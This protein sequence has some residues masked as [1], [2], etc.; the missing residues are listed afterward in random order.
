MARTV[1]L[2]NLLAQ[3]RYLGNIQGMTAR[4][5]DS[6]LTRAINQS[7]QHF[8]E[9]VSAH[10]VRNYLTHATGTLSVG[11]TSPFAFTVLD[12]SAVSPAIVRVFGLDITV[13]GRV[14]PLEQIDFDSRNDFQD[15]TAT[16]L[17]QEPVAYANYQQARLAIFPASSGAYPYTVHYLPVLADLTSGFDTFD[18]VVGWEEWVACDV[19]LKVLQRDEYAAIVAMANDM[20]DRVWADIERNCNPVK[21]GGIVRRI[22]SRELRNNRL[23]RRASW[24]NQ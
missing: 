9:K 12:L 24:W 17:L 1:T 16:T 6:D 21:S 13:Q 14:V 18:G 22:D 11:A 10:G 7:I 23:R 3:V 15:W 5:T 19:L 20:R 8:R 2:T 4:H